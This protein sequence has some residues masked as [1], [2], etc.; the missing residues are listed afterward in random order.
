MRTR[1]K[2]VWIFICCGIAAVLILTLSSEREPRYAGDTLSEWVLRLGVANGQLPP[3]ML[4]VTNGIQGLTLSDLAR[5]LQERADGSNAETAIQHI[6][7][8]AVPFLIKWTDYHEGPWRGRLALLC[9]KLPKKLAAPAGRLFNSDGYLRQQGAY[10]ALAI[11]GPQAKP[12]IPAL[13]RQL[14]TPAQIRALLPLMVLASIG[15][16]GLPTLVEILRNPA[17]ANR[18]AAIFA[19]GQMDLGPILDENVTA[20]LISCL[21]DPQAAVALRA[22][23]ILCSHKFDQEVVMRFFTAALEAN[24]RHI[25]QD[26]AMPIRI[27][28][29]Q[30]L[31]VPTLL[32]LL[33][34]TNSPYSPDAA[35][36]LGNM[37]SSDIH[38]PDIVCPALIG[39]LRDPRA[40]VRKHAAIAIGNL[41]EDAE[42][43][44]SSLLD[45]WN[46]PDD[47]V[48]Q[49][50]TNALYQI[51]PYTVLKDVAVLDSVSTEP[52][53]TKWI[54]RCINDTAA[55][56][57]TRVLQHHDPRI[58]ELATN[59]LQK[60]SENS[61]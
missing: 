30:G 10:Y 14:E 34:D 11:L 27:C 53:R 19:L 48:R 18:A 47:S 58:R 46:D 51:P 26:A 57:F 42:P 7:P 6:G 49:N 12:A 32:D 39:S 2:R 33:R 8:S 60:L 25:R 61:F 35:V 13:K 23:G 44:V 9:S 52:A 50:A 36:V 43:A 17:N 5:M 22:G 24:D 21:D 45:L 16:D 1:R 41:R 20:A 59:A 31:S 40:N 54:H 3:P 56:P 38:L 55:P 4:F 28:I 29:M 37:L 15:K